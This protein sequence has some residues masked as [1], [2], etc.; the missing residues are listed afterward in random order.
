[1]TSNRVALV[2]AIVEFSQIAV[3]MLA[4]HRMI[5][6]DDAALEEREISFDVLMCQK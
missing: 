4:T 6:A 2:V 1:V 5:D 3:Q